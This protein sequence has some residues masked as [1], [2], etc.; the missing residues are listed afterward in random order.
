MSAVCQVKLGYRTPANL[1]GVCESTMDLTLQKPITLVMG[2]SIVSGP[3]FWN[4]TQTCETHGCNTA[5]LPI[6]MLHPKNDFCKTF[7]DSTQ[8][9]IFTECTT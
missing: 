4:R 5:E 3:E 8:L 2:H 6:C 1:F 9:F 7:L